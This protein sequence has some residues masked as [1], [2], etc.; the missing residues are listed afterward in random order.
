M[1]V[2]TLSQ[3]LNLWNTVLRIRVRPSRKP[4]SYL[5]PRSGSYCILSTWKWTELIFRYC[6]IT[7]GNKYCKQFNFRGNLNSDA[8]TGSGPASM[9]QRVEKKPRERKRKKDRQ[10]KMNGNGTGLFPCTRLRAPAVDQCSP[11]CPG[12]SISGWSKIAEKNI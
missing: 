5:K 10:K 9:F 8:Q 2:S 1:Q 6:I 11:I 12:C 7:L 3:N 4:G